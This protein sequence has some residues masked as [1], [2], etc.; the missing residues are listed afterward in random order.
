MYLTYQE[1]AGKDGGV[2]AA[3][4]ARLAAKAE[5][6]VDR[7]THGRLKG[8]EPVREAVKSCVFELIGELCREE[9]ARE[10][11][12]GREL[13]SMSNDGL[14]VSFAAQSAAGG[15]SPRQMQILRQW[16]GDELSRD[17][18]NLLYAGTDG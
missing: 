3:A 13:A 17:G 8:E 16:L 9:A 2:D 7:A 10:M 1:Y 11:D 5:K 6:L 4:F 18:V 14:S 12:G 15:A